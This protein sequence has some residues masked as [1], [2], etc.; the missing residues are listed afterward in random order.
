MASIDAIGESDDGLHDVDVVDHQIQHDVHIGA[1]LLVRR[2]SMTLDEA[3]RFQMRLGGEDRRVE[4]LEMPDLEHD[5][6]SP[7]RAR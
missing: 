5:I 7:S 3:W 1:A 6:L 2:E 4:T